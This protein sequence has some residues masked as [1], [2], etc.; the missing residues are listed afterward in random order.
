MV[1]LQ[2]KRWLRMAGESL[3]GR[4][5][6][7]LFSFCPWWHHTPAFTLGKFIWIQTDMKKNLSEHSVD[8][9]KDVLKYK[10]T[11][12]TSNIKRQKDLVN[13][14][15]M[16]FAYKSMAIIMHKVA[17]FCFVYFCWRHV[18]KSRALV[19]QACCTSDSCSSMCEQWVLC[20]QVKV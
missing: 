2:R 13:H 9:Y 4:N 5:K 10:Y 3:C 1:T 15:P 20:W 19:V 7:C 6:F 16:L 12:Q 8:F 18:R 11:K 14:F 17:L